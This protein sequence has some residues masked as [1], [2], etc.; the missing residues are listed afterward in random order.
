MVEVFLPPHEHVGVGIGGRVVFI[1]VAD[2]VDKGVDLD[3]SLGVEHGTDGLFIHVGFVG[4]V[5]FFG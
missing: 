5:G 1:L 3:S 4:E 2:F